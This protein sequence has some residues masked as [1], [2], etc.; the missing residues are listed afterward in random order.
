MMNG[1]GFVA[2]KATES[3]DAVNA[4]AVR[5]F[6]PLVLPFFAARFLF[7]LRRRLARWNS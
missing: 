6:I 3:I 2:A 4:D 7:A 5:V 1:L